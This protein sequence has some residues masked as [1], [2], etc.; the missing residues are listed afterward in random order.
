VEI[1]PETRRWA[2]RIAEALGLLRDSPAA[3]D[4]W[5]LAVKTP[6]VVSDLWAGP[7]ASALWRRVYL[8]RRTMDL[9]T[10]DLAALLAHELVHVR[11]GIW[12]YSSIEAEREAYLV[13]TRVLLGL[14]GHR[15]PPPEAEI[16]AAQADLQALQTNSRARAWIVARGP[17][18][19]WFPERQPRIWQVTQ[20]W[21]Q[22]R[23]AVLRSWRKRRNS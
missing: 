14:L 1:G 13:Q 7:G 20:W 17:S 2:G 23:E 19:R 21:P 15:V 5:T 3:G 18:Y 12:F 22:V 9:Q 4:L 11:Q 8:S 10:E 16:A 6:V